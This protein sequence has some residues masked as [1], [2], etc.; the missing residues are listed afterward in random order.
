[1]S[2]LFDLDIEPEPEQPEIDVL[3]PEVVSLQ[4]RQS[5]PAGFNLPTL[6][7]FLPDIRLKQ[8]AEAAAEKALAIDVSEEGGLLAADAAL[9]PLRESIEAITRDFEDPTSLANQLHK[10]LTGLRSDFSKVASAALET[11]SR[12]VYAENKRQE[13]MAAEARRKAQDAADK[14]AREDAKKAADAAKAAGQSKAVV[15][16]LKQQAK[17]AVAAPVASPAPAP[18]LASTSTVPKWKVR[19]VGTPSDGTANPEI[20]ELTAQQQEQM[21]KVLL[22]V[23]NGQLPLAVTLGLNWS[24][25]NKRAVAEKTT[26][27]MLELEAFDEGGTRKKR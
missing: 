20:D 19:F 7:R 17:T 22:A 21:R 14:Q 13:A 16:T 6:L 9:V 25:L 24:Y 12:R 27:E 10:R 2:N 3:E 4:I 11:V 8:R 26:F 18:M 1:M 23:G 15:E 5:L